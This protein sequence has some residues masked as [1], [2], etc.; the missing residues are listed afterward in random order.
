MAA[1]SVGSQNII[2][3]R[4]E[5]WYS[6]Y[7]YDNK[8]GL[9]NAKR[10]NANVM[11]K[12]VGIKGD[13]QHGLRS[14]YEWTTLQEDINEG[15]DKGIIRMKPRWVQV[16]FEDLDEEFEWADADDDRLLFICSCPSQ[17]DQDRTIMQQVE[18]KCQGRSNVELTFN[19]DTD[20]A[21]SVFENM[22]IGGGGGGSGGGE[23]GGGVEGA[24]EGGEGGGGAGQG[25]DG[26]RRAAA[27][28]TEASVPAVSARAG[29][30]LNKKMAD[31]FGRSYTYSGTVNE[32]GEPHGKGVE[33]WTNGDVFEGGYRNG[34]RH[35]KGCYTDRNGFI[36]DGEYVNDQWHGKGT[37][38]F[39]DG[40]AEVVQYDMGKPTGEAAQWNCDRTRA[41]RLMNGEPEDEISLEEAAQI[42]DRLGLP[43]P[44][45]STPVPAP[46]KL[47]ADTSGEPPVPPKSFGP[48]S[49]ADMAEAYDELEEIIRELGLREGLR[50]LEANREGLRELEA[51]DSTAM[52]KE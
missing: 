45:P 17:I 43:V 5:A 38:T 26:G 22:N 52:E 29:E 4:K 32:A 15:I 19:W 50:E 7:F 16:E 46:Y 6:A 13:L 33:E 21:A 9:N 51:K 37:F 3:V 23:Q 35:G 36:F 30:V 1:L 42:A 39:G 49:A 24:V 11:I 25:G 28:A 47:C 8:Q 41:W 10:K 18:D 40:V 27:V 48:L 14:R 2:D 20:A 44:A 31:P 34:K 12:M